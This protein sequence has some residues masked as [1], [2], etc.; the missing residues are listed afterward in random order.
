[1]ID[2]DRARDA[3]RREVRI[4]RVEGHGAVVLAGVDF[5]AQVVAR[6]EGVF[7]LDAERQRQPLGAGEA[8][9]QLQ[10][11]GGLFS[12]VDVQVDL[13]GRAGHIGG[14]DVD[15][16]EEAQA[17]HPVARQ[18]DALGVVPGG[19]ELPELAAHHFVARAVV[20]ATC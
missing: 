15:F 5:N 8:C 1:V 6:A 19:L 3:V 16:L 20:A 4:H 11:A 14:F 18:L 10:A 9:A 7:L 12:D 13:V 17:V 2:V